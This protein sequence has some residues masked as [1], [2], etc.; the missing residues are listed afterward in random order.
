MTKPRTDW[1]TKM[2]FYLGYRVV[3]DDEQLRAFNACIKAIKKQKNK[4][5]KK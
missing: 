2:Y 3:E 4:K 1:A 5:V